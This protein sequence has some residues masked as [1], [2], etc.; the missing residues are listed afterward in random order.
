MRLSTMFIAFSIRRSVQWLVL[1]GIL[2]LPGWGAVPVIFDTDMGNDIDDALALAMLHSLENRG[3]CKLLGVTLTN[4]NR[5]AVPYIRMVNR[6]YGRPAIPVGSA[7]RVIKDGDRDGFLSVP[8][9]AAPRELRVTDRRAPENAVPLLR[10]LLAESK[11]KV[12]I[13]QVGFS[14]NLAA[15][16]D[17][18]P[19]AISNFSG[20]E[21]VR[22]KV[23]LLSV[24]AGNFVETTPEYNVRLDIP[25]AQALA[26][27]WPTPIVFSGFEIGRALKYPAR[28]I[29]N[30][31]GYVKWHPIP[32]S[33]AAYQKM[34]YDRP[35]WDLTSVLYAVRPDAG[36]FQLSEP[37]NVSVDS[38]TGS[39]KFTPSASGPHRYLVIPPNGDDR[40]LEAL[41]LLSSE[42]PRAVK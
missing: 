14:T 3:E 26:D 5:D 27:R 36:Y 18:P 30:D 7:T 28:S 25:A 38:S 34:P 37:G 17:S 4:A 1:M 32:V 33:Y 22:Q 6:F 39:T 31:Y 40:I 9:K 19:D 42:P 29:E 41:M 8:L 23:S 24:M 11:E 2:L 12:V 13:V 35:T 16:L 15:L 20:L 10:R 21:L